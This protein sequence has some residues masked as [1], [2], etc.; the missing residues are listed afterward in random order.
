ML[1]ELIQQ[2]PSEDCGCP[3]EVWD[4]NGICVVIHL[5]EDGSGHIFLDAG[6]WDDEKLVECTGIIDL[7]NK[8]ERWVAALPVC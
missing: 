2:R 3:E 4:M 7:K 1:C 6:D 5:E 8:A